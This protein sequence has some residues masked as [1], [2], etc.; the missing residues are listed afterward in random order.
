[1]ATK[2]KARPG[3]YYSGFDHLAYLPNQIVPE[4]PIDLRFASFQRRLQKAMDV[5]TLDNQSVI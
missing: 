2:P 3:S 4:I 1:M 5:A